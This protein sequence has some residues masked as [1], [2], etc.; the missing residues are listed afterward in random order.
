MQKNLPVTG[1][2]V[3]IFDYGNVISGP[4]NKE[5]IQRISQKLGLK[6][7][8]EFKSLYLIHRK[9]IDSGLISL[10]EYWARTVK[11]INLSLSGEDLDWLAQEDIKSWADI[12]EDTIGLIRELKKER[13]RLAI[14]SNMVTETLDYLKKNTSFIDYFDHCFFSCEINMIKPNTELYQYVLKEMGAHPRDC[15]FIDDIPANCEAA[16]QLGMHAIRFA[17]V[18]NLRIELDKMLAA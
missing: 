1:R 16:E 8:E 17:D 10:K 3:L 11:A 18:Q 7:T 4:Q 5:C 15:I 14:L 12:N 2:Q 13:Y 9:D 6:N